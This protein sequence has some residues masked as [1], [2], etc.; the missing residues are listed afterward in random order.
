MRKPQVDKPNYLTMPY[1]SRERWI[2]FWYQILEVTE[3][4]KGKDR[5]LPLEGSDPSERSVLEV[6]PGPGI[7]SSVLRNTGVRVTT[8]DIDE[9]L[10]PRTVGDVTKLPFADRSFDTVLIAEVLEH[11]PF[12]EVPRALSELS[13]VVKTSLV[14]TLP[15]FSHFVPSIAFKLFPFI[16][17]FSKVFP[18][19]FPVR[20]RFD[21]QHYW[22]IG[23]WGSPLSSIR[24]ILTTHTGFALKKDYLIEENP[25]HHVFVLNRE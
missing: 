22:E 14:I 19:S 6:G 9:R 25:F 24:H 2:S 1:L 16:P 12:R 4:L 20:H 15:H 11:I 7:V 8:L 10:K 23:K 17:R 18:V 21:G 13:R 5:I 3:S